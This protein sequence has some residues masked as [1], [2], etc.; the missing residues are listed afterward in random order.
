M[1]SASY[2]LKV[3]GMQKVVTEYAVCHYCGSE[4][5]EAEGTIACAR[6]I[7]EMEAKYPIYDWHDNG[8]E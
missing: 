3:R 5:V 2:H 4:I 6:C 1:T 8:S 7:K